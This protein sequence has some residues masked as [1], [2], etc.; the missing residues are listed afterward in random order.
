MRIRAQKLN[1]SNCKSFNIENQS[2]KK[3][4][5]KWN[6]EA[7]NE[8]PTK[9]STASNLRVKRIN[10]IGNISQNIQIRGVEYKKSVDKLDR[11]KSRSFSRI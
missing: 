3:L 4:N 2:T 5:L 1:K 9:Y 11:N 8:S 6:T 10:S 7:S